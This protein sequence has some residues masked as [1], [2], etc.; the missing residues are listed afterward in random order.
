MWWRQ[1]GWG[2]RK[3]D[4]VISSR[5]QDHMRRRSWRGVDAV[6]NFVFN[7][8]GPARKELKKLLDNTVQILAWL[9]RIC[10]LIAANSQ[11]EP[12]QFL[13]LHSKPIG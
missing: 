9:F 4:W 2:R 13:L 12:T 6:Q 7:D 11:S 1:R 3:V 8:G 10:G 5:I